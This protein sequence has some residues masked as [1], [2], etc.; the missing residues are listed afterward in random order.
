M[1][2]FKKGKYTL[3]HTVFR[4]DM[5]FE[6]DSF[7]LTWCDDKGFKYRKPIMAPFR[8]V[9]TNLIFEPLRPYSKKEYEEILDEAIEHHETN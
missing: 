9:V 4:T 2:T 1:K 5:G 6:M 3:E 7:E 8:E